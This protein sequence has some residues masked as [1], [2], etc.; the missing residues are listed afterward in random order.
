MS[1]AVAAQANDFG[2]IVT[3]LDLRNLC[4]G[5]IRRIRDLWLQYQVLAFPDQPLEHEQLLNFTSA[6]GAFGEEP[7]VAPLRDQQ[8]ILEIRREPSEA[9]SPFGASWHSDW[10]F[11]AQPP[12]A[13][14]AA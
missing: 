7:Y 6:I 3:G 14:I 11:Q 12:A 13:K 5:D 10:S 1:V 8:H 4:A 9:I 2:A